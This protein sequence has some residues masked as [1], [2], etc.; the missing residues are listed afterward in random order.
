MIDPSGHAPCNIFGTCPDS[1]GIRI[2]TSLMVNLGKDDILVGA[3]IAVQAEWVDFP[4]HNSSSG[5]GSSQLSRAQLD[6]AYGKKVNNSEQFGL[7]LEGQNPNNQTTAYV[8]MSRR[9]YQVVDACNFCSSTDKIIVAALAQ[10]NGFTLDSLLKDVKS[11]YYNKTTGINWGLYFDSRSSSGGLLKFRAWGS[12]QGVGSFD[13]R[14]QLLL[15]TNDLIALY[16]FGYK[17]PYDLDL[18]DIYEIRETYLND[19]SYNLRDLPTNNAQTP[20]QIPV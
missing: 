19:T 4:F 16:N 6:T 11:T 18:Q 12:G 8:G 5:Q 17:L 15:Y 2:A 3:G 1:R 9:I 20:T 7:G 10:N 14:F 13:T